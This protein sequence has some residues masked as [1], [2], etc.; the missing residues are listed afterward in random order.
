[1]ANSLIQSQS[2]FSNLGGGATA[3]LA[4]TTQN[5]T[6]GNML[7]ATIVSSGLGITV[8]SVTDNQG[9]GNTWVVI[10]VISNS[11]YNVYLAYALNTIGGTEPTVS[12]HFA[13]GNSVAC[14]I[15]LGEV[16][17]PNAFRSHDTGNTGAT[18]TTFTSN[19]I[20]AVAGDFLLG[21]YARASTSLISDLTAPGYTLGPTGGAT[22]GQYIVASEYLLSASAGSATASFN[23]TFSNANWACG[24][25]AFFTA[26]TP[27]S[28]TAWSPVDSRQAVPG[29]GP[30]P[31]AFRTVQGSSIYDVQTSSNPAVPGKDSRT[32][33]PTDCRIA[34]N[35][36]QNSRAPEV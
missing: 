15:G 14:Y 24:I 18:G 5:T 32:V 31:N 30:G 13:G 6:A 29:F 35:I 19:P 3:S 7:F 10:P 36:P 34:P 22:A 28:P 12:A 17:G 26:V 20:T 1:M 27:P 2:V 33:K 21:Y 8:S 16:S 25:A 9:A 4:F 23:D 11:T